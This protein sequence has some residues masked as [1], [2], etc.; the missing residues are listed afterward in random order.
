[1][2]SI[3]IK[4]FALALLCV[5]ALFG[6]N[7]PKPE[8][9]ILRSLEHNISYLADDHLEG[10]LVGS[11]GEKLAYEFIIENFQSINIV[12]LCQVLKADI[13]LSIR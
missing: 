6:Q 11:R 12:L 5:Q 2:K 13:F 3:H 4:F 9:E 7:L 10:R 1:M 8:E